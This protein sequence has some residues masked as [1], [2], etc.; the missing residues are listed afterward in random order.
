[1]HFLCEAFV[2]AVVFALNTQYQCVHVNGYS[3][4]CT[5][6]LGKECVA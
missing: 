2:V 3:K 5:Q 4:F 1:M 6:F